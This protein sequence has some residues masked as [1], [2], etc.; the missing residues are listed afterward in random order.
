M[1]PDKAWIYV[2]HGALWLAHVN[3]WNFVDPVNV[4]H[5]DEDQTT[6]ER[7]AGFRLVFSFACG[8]ERLMNGFPA[9]SLNQLSA[10]N[11]TASF[12][13]DDCKIDGEEGR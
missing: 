2:I 6:T 12:C 5:N 10:H 9:L 1:Q 7:N 3:M 4:P 13:K 11:L 8:N